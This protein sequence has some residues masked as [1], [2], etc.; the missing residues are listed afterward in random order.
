[1]DPHSLRPADANFTR[2]MDQHDPDVAAEVP[3][4]LPIH[5]GLSALPAVLKS[6]P[7]PTTVHPFGVT[8][9]L[10][11]PSA[12]R[13]DPQSSVIAEIARD[14]G[15][16]APQWAARHIA[17][18][19]NVSTESL[20]PAAALVLQSIQAAMRGHGTAA[21]T[22]PASVEVNFSDSHQTSDGGKNAALPWSSRLRSSG[23]ALDESSA[24]SRPVAPTAAS[25][26]TAAPIVNNSDGPAARTR[27]KKA[28]GATP[29]AKQLKGETKDEE[30][31]VLEGAPAGEDS[32][33]PAAAP[34]RGRPPKLSEGQ[35][36][37]TSS[38]PSDL[39]AVKSE[40]A[41]A[42]ADTL[43]A[44]IASDEDS[45]GAT[46]LQR[47][48]KARAAVRAA[49][50]SPQD[51]GE[52]PVAVEALGTRAA[53]KCFDK[54]NATA[55]GAKVAGTIG[56]L[57]ALGLAILQTGL[58]APD[59]AVADAALDALAVLQRDLVKRL[60]D[61]SPIG[62]H[63]TGATASGAVK[64]TKTTS[65]AAAVSPL[66]TDVLLHVRDCLTTLRQLVHQ[67]LVLAS[68]AAASPHR[69]AAPRD[70]GAVLSDGQLVRLEDFVADV[71]T[72][73]IKPGIGYTGDWARNPVG[74]YVCAPA[75]EL[76]TILAATRNGASDRMLAG[77]VAALPEA[78]LS[79]DARLATVAAESGVPRPIGVAAAACLHLAMAG[80][81]ILPWGVR[82]ELA[83]VTTS[84]AISDTTTTSHAEI[85]AA[86]VAPAH[87]LDR[88]AGIARRFVDGV[89]RKYFTAD[90]VAAHPGVK[91]GAIQ[92]FASF[93]D[94]LA[95]SLHAVEF[96]VAD[97]ALRHL[98][99]AV[100]KGCLR[101]DGALTAKAPAAVAGKMRRAAVDIVGSVALA[102]LR[103][104]R[105]IDPDTA[106][107]ELAWVS[108]ADTQ[109]FAQALESTWVRS[110][111]QTHHGKAAGTKGK[112]HTATAKVPAMP[113]AA[114]S[115]PLRD[116]IQVVRY[117][118]LSAAYDADPPSHL[119][120]LLA[121]QFHA[122]AW[123]AD[124]AVRSAAESS[125]ASGGA[126]AKKKGKST[127]PAPSTSPPPRLS[128]GAMLSHVPSRH[129]PPPALRYTD[130]TY[131]MLRSQ[132]VTISAEDTKSLFHPDASEVLLH[133]LLSCLRDEPGDSADAA[134]TGWDAARTS[135]TVS[136]AAMVKE[137]PSLLLPAFVTIR[138]A[139]GSNGARVREAAVG[140]LSALFA[141]VEAHLAARFDGANQQQSQSQVSHGMPSSGS[142]LEDSR[143]YEVVA[144]SMVSAMMELATDRS[145]LV[146][147][148]A[149]SA[150]VQLLRESSWLL[151]HPRTERSV[152][153]RLVALFALRGSPTPPIA[154]KQYAA[155]AHALLQ[156]WFGNVAV[157]VSHGGDASAAGAAD[158]G[159]AAAEVDEDDEDRTFIS[160]AAEIMRAGR[161]AGTTRG[162]GS[163]S[164]AT[165][166]CLC[167]DRRSKFLSADQRTA[168]TAAELVAL[169][170]DGLLPP[171][172]FDLATH[173]LA[174]VLGKPHAGAFTVAPRP[175]AA[176]RVAKDND[177]AASG[178]D[179][180]GPAVNAAEPAMGKAA[181][182]A[183][184]P[185]PA[186]LSNRVFHRGAEPVVHY[187]ATVAT[188]AVAHLPPIGH[189]APGSAYE[190]LDQPT[191]H[192][193]SHDGETQIKLMPRGTSLAL[194]CLL[195]GVQQGIAETTADALFGLLKLL[196]A[197]TA[198]LP[199]S[200]HP[201]A[202]A[203]AE[204]RAVCTFHLCRLLLSV[205]R[206]VPTAELFQTLTSMLNKYIGPHQQLVLIAAVRCLCGACSRGPEDDS[207]EVSGGGPA[208]H[209]TA[210][211]PRPGRHVFAVLNQQFQRLRSVTAK[212][213]TDPASQAYGCRFVFLL[214]ELL[215]AVDWNHGTPPQR[216]EL[217]RMATAPLE[218]MLAK[219]PPH[220]GTAAVVHLVFSATVAFV[221]ACPP[222]S[223]A[224]A[225]SV[226]VRVFASCA[227]QVPSDFWPK[228]E[229]YVHRCLAEATSGA[230][231]STSTDALLLH[232][233]GVTAIR[234][235]LVHEERRV[236]AAAEAVAA[237]KKV[238]DKEYNSGMATWVLQR[239]H[240]SVRRLAG[241]PQAA[242]RAAAAEVI[243]LSIHQGLLAPVMFVEPLIALAADPFPAA[244]T[245]DRATTVLRLISERH[246]DALAHKSIDGVLLAF[247]TGRLA[248][249]SQSHTGFR[250]ASEWQAA[251]SVHATLYRLIA[252]AKKP[253][254]T[255][256]AGILRHLHNDS[257]LQAVHGPLDTRI[258]MLAYLTRTC[259]TLPINTD[260]E[261]A[262]ILTQTR[263]A[264]DVCAEAAGQWLERKAAS[265][266]R[267]P[268]TPSATDD[269]SEV[270]RMTG[271]LLIHSLRRFVCREYGYSAARVQRLL[272]RVAA[273]SSTS[274]S[275]PL[276]P[277]S[278]SAFATLLADI[279]EVT[280]TMKA[281]G[282]SLTTQAPSAETTPAGETTAAAENSA[283]G[284]RAGGK[285]ATSTAAA[286]RARTT[287]VS[288][289]REAYRMMVEDASK[290]LILTTGGS[291]GEGAAAKSVARRRVGRRARED[292]SSSSSS[293]DEEGNSDV[294]S[295]DAGSDDDS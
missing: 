189:A 92:F 232:L 236:V 210:A 25:T 153:G 195:S 279:D 168:A 143:T 147:T 119:T 2:Y 258:E 79:A 69:F 106:L 133:H 154:E 262:V 243:E 177:E 23:K 255:F 85:A 183:A 196:A 102:A 229:P 146:A 182:A 61:E 40:A 203:A 32:K 169:T 96:P 132:W 197:A 173:P 14:V 50:A 191:S 167:S 91:G 225:L 99:A 77:I 81:S 164:S 74:A 88:T 13:Y 54:A 105:W 156:R 181:K 280:V 48:A 66:V 47:I 107:C 113:T 206:T 240:Q 73:V 184:A 226:A 163:S 104:A 57:V 257:R 151:S 275:L 212:A 98:V 72:G 267:N 59:D 281:L 36:L 276:R 188:G 90:V 140:L 155:I 15:R 190:A 62:G 30:G 159:A 166:S 179:A 33:P 100:V 161:A 31:E 284:K 109:S 44:F 97:S 126:S 198:P 216:E 49:E 208:G 41:S 65:K 238:S 22:A 201:A 272:D 237:T 285:K 39:A 230:A 121:R 111:V 115:T 187:L 117:H 45:K 199:T 254:E 175:A 51:E 94:D 227:M 124:D 46:F 5:A 28:S 144:G 83:T 224:R 52:V 145:T 193:S 292:E 12:A 118:V 16:I 26:S 70:I 287:A 221:D 252:R 274:Q 101:P 266:A 82:P 223:Q 127:D 137:R 185:K 84:L 63:A 256:L 218:N 141:Q 21:G 245:S 18:T 160:R 150:L 265:G 235:F 3:P 248:T 38:A 269:E 205:G 233:Q 142:Q 75:L 158:G 122:A 290:D 89:M 80:G 273:G 60:R 130:A 270:L 27:S 20:S 192:G 116:R 11:V 283:S 286:P 17:F 253:R 211:M 131:R 139:L 108:D 34:R 120:A 171:Y 87:V 278:S 231:S 42:L 19:K 200:D 138:K 37:P 56:P 71:L 294:S 123:A 93:A 260:T 246:E 152:V 271:L 250:D 180:D 228:A 209:H 264:F 35:L 76:L 157:S 207:E 148:K 215:R 239:F 129:G 67:Q 95:S 202:Q 128:C 249:G 29:P 162:G 261:L 204:E 64:A 78:H 293:D 251:Q 178:S 6:F 103:A 176:D 259:A 268:P 58:C 86:A 186:L 7:V 10:T 43:N 136:M 244:Y 125:N 241:S 277:P 53:K 242:C 219:C 291:G 247:T 288:K 24:T 234:D 68:T 134:A 194:L 220:M 170:V 4:L 214:S 8:P 263:T 1:V 55:A 174:R 114:A 282:S 110:N 289:A 295:S 222:E 135:A 149:T 112:A 172:D 217:G 9:P 213:G 165:S